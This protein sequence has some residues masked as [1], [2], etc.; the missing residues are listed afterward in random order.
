M[1][2]FILIGLGFI[3]FGVTQEAMK[4]MKTAE[5]APAAPAAAP[6][7]DPLAK[8]KPNPEPAPAA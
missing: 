8:I 4:K 7:V 2:V 3:G 6:G 5:P 1:N